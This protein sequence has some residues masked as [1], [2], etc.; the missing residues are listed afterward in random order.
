[1]SSL[2]IHDPVLHEFAASV[3]SVGPV[4]VAGGRT[5]WEVGGRLD[6]DAHIL[7][8]PTGIVAYSAP[9]MTVQVRAGTPVAELDAALAAE[10]Q[11]TALPNRGG[12]VGGAVAVGE[13]V[14]E[15]MGRGRLRDAVLQIRYVS[16]EGELVTSG[17]PV[18]KN[19]TGYNLPRLLAGSLGTLGLIAEVILRTNPI[20]AA[21]RWLCAGDAN[22]KGAFAAV[23]APSAVLWNGTDTWVLLEGHQPDIDA[24]SKTLQAAGSFIEVDGP[25]A[26]PENRW[27]IGPSEVYELRA[28]AAGDFVASVGVGTVWAS[29][30]EPARLADSASAQIAGRLKQKFDPTGRLNPGRRVEH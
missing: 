30:P 6:P 5:R 18:V 4:A 10:G 22:P 20:P 23:Y 24:E 7:D 9:E 26:L 1:M 28:R 13:N 19:V 27:S 3:G 16:A 14:L 29:Q 11:R 25:P 21:S 8:A 2:A 17:G 12:T 15:V